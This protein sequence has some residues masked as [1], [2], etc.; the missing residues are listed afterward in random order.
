MPFCKGVTRT[1]FEISFE[2]GGFLFVVETDR[3]FDFPGLVFRAVRGFA[4][5]VFFE[6]AFHVVGQSNICLAWIR[7]TA[8]EVDVLHEGIL[9]PW[10]F[11]AQSFCNTGEKLGGTMIQGGLVRSCFA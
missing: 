4:V 6:T 5:V 11:H 2:E 1:G 9:R 8:E 3:D 10:Y 7:E